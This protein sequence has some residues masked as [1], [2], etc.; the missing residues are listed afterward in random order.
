MHNDLFSIGGLT[1][2]GY[3]LCIGLGIAAALLLIWRRAE[4]RRLD[5][6]TV[7]TL[8]LLI[9]AAGFAGAKI[10]FLFAHWS[11]F[12]ANPPG[13]LGSEGFVVYGGI[14]CGLGA[15]YLYCRKRS[16][17]FLRWADCFVPGV[18]LAQGFGRIGC[19][20]AGC[21]F[22]KPTDS[23]FGVVFPAGSA[24]PA[25]VPLWPV[26]LFSAAGDLL[27]AGTLLLL[28]KKRRGDGLLTGAYLLLYSV[29]RFL[30]EFLRADPRGAVGIFSTSQ[31]IALF[32]AAA[33]AVILLLRKR[34]TSHE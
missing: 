4:E 11:E 5:A 12:R 18:A 2:H 34:G 9:L 23:I 1:V 10:F 24:A 3:G 14:V 17:P 29:G 13:V 15:A 26:Q 31:L 16:L 22:G 30:I 8:V 6:K 20:L 19:F 21:C 33:A 28:E 25:G 7:N 32:A 27:L